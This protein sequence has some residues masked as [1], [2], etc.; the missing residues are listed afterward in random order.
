MPTLLL[1]TG[2]ALVLLTCMT[3]AAA[4]QA[5]GIRV[6]RD[7]ADAQLKVEAPV[8]SELTGLQNSGEA[9]LRRELQSR[10]CRRQ[11][12]ARAL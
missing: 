12:V 6:V 10:Q 5:L 1:M 9:R 7:Q 11:M 2:L 8:S 3:T 4:A